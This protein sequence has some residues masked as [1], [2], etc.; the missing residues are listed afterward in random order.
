MP[1]SRPKYRNPKVPEENKQMK[2]KF[3]VKVSGLSVKLFISQCTYFATLNIIMTL[4]R[5]GDVGEEDGEQRGAKE[6]IQNK[7]GI[8]GTGIGDGGVGGYTR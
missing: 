8:S 4:P 1:L 6:R 7:G 2:L 5:T 3:S